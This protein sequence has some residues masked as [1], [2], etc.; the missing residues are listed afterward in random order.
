MYFS[1]LSPHCDCQGPRDLQQ[2]TASVELSPPES[3]S[4]AEANSAQARP[5]GPRTLETVV[6]WCLPKYLHCSV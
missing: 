4:L 6:V 5:A 2:V 1:S 3:G